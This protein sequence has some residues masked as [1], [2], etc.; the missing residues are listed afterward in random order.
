MS[1]IHE[2]LRFELLCLRNRALAWFQW[3]REQLTVWLTEMKAWAAAVTW[4]ARIA[5]MFELDIVGLI[6]I[7]H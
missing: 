7:V 6:E 3:G 5:D 4:R 1:V 2:V